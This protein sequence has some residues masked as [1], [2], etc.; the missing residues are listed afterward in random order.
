MGLFSNLWF[1]IT[2]LRS[3]IIFQNDRRDLMSIFGTSGVNMH[4]GFYWLT[5]IGREAFVTISTDY[6][7][8]HDTVAPAGFRFYGVTLWLGFWAYATDIDRN[9]QRGFRNGICSLLFSSWNPNI[10]YPIR[11]QLSSCRSTVHEYHIDN[12]CSTCIYGDQGPLLLTWF[13]FNP[14]WIRDYMPRKVWD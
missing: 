9:L 2:S 3:D 4:K 13:N 10:G 1:R 7:Y 12:I 5:I 14:T 11:L 8:I 6:C